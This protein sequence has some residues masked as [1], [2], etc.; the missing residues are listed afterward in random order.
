MVFNSGLVSYLG[1]KVN[2]KKLFLLDFWF[3]RGWNLE[4]WEKKIKIV[5]R[6]WFYCFF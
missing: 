5:K 2:I 6:E 1:Y 4:L 3:L